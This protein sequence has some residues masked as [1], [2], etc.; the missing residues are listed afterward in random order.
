MLIAVRDD[1]TCFFTDPE[2]LAVAYRDFP[3]IRLSL[4]IVPFA[5]PR[6]GDRPF[7]ARASS[8]ARGEF[9]LA[10][11]RDLIQYLSQGDHEIMLH[12]FSHEY[13]K[14]G[15]TWKP[16]YVWRSKEELTSLTLKG[17]MHL[18][19]TLGK[20]VQVFVAPSNR[21]ACAGI[22]ALEEAG[23]DFC[24]IIQHFDRPISARYLCN[25]VRRWTYRAFV[26]LPYPFILDYGRHQ[27]LFGWP[28]RSYDY[29]ERAYRIHKQTDTPFVITTHYWVMMS[30]KDIHDAVL[31][32][33]SKA[34][35]EGAVPVGVSGCF[36][37]R[38]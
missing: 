14:H 25:Y 18:E 29:L 22:E 30:N 24:G 16:E 1:D 36:Q 28:A 26:G 12:G 15:N 38:G 4:A 33:V 7:N 6:H 10:G 11:N 27:E 34:L 20:K 31:R 17:K 8:Y 35:D 2:D 3:P 37:W 13:K 9:A 23:L 32:I 19:D 21:I 5:F